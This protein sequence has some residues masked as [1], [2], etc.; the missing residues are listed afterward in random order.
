MTNPEKIPAVSYMVEVIADSSGTWCGNGLRFATAAEADA[1]G[2]DLACRWTAVSDFRVV[3]SQ[4]PV[5]R[6]SR[7]R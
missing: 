3:P 7:D 2:F 1:Y 6:P 5:N 4:D